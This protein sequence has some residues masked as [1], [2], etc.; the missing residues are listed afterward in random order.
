MAH[1]ARPEPTHDKHAQYLVPDVYQ[2]T[3]VSK[4]HDA[5]QV[6]PTQNCRRFPTAHPE[7]L[8][9]PT[10]Q[11]PPQADQP[12]EHSSLHSMT[13]TLTD[14]TDDSDKDPIGDPQVAHPTQLKTTTTVASA[15]H[16]TSET[17][18]DTSRK[19]PRD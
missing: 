10:P 19:M 9:Y 15:L 6:Q 18:P 1:A 13:A 4:S 7:H 12:A 3:Q 8:L 5:V 11:L 17:M 2:E 14:Q 16:K